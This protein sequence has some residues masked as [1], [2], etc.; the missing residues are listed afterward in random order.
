MNRPFSRIAALLLLAGL[1]MPLGPVLAGAPIPPGNHVADATTRFLD[2]LRSGPRFLRDAGGIITDRQTGLQWLEGPDRPTSWE[3][4][5]AWISGLGGDWRTPTLAELSALYLP[6]S[7]R[8]GTYGDPL[9]L[10]PVFKRE[11]GYCLWSVERFDG[12][13]WLYDFSRGYAHWID[14]YF[15]GRFDRAVAVRNP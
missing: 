6:D 10:D 15:P 1:L 2:E 8:K 9:C 13:A 12:T 7:D 4:A 5:Q 3:Q 14:T 11:S